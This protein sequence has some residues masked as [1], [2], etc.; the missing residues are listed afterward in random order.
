MRVTTKIK[1]L[2][3]RTLAIG[4]LEK[5]L[6]L[7]IVAI[8]DDPGLRWTSVFIGQRAKRICGQ[9]LDVRLFVG[10]QVV[11][12][13]QRISLGLEIDDEQVII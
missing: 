2:F 8:A 6:N 1:Q 4:M 7:R 5:W 13:A 9:L 3:A 11:R 12:I 10:I